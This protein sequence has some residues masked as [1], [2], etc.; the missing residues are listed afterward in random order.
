MEN[1][2]H[3][4]TIDWELALRLAGNKQDLAEEIFGMFVK[5]LPDDLSKLNQLHQ[6]SN[7]SELLRHVH[8]L[9][10]AICYCGVPRLKAIIARIEMDLKNK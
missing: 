8:R 5:M 1:I 10:G 9:H 4:P 7:Y 3:L 6:N 2:N